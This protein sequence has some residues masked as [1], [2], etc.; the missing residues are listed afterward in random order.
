MIQKIDNRLFDE[1]WQDREGMNRAVRQAVRDALRRHMLLG[2][3]V[4]AGDENGK[5]KILGPQEIRKV[6]D[7]E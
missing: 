6:L 7:A 2:E 1:R 4:A 5:V 3:S